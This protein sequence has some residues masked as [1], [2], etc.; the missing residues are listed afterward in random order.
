MCSLFC[1]GY[2][3]CSSV[4]GCPARKHVERAVDD[5]AMLIVTYEGEHRHS[6][7]PLP[8]NVTAN[9]AMRHVFQSTWETRKSHWWCWLIHLRRLRKGLDSVAVTV[10]WRYHLGEE[11]KKKK[12]KSVMDCKEFQGWKWR[13]TI[14]WPG[15]FDFV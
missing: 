6:H 14:K 5:P 13:A 15:N 4:R 8:E 3:K 9:A 1:R 12:K 10:T 2:Y 7:A 11:S